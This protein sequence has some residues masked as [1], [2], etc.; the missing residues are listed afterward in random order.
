MLGTFHLYSNFDH[1]QTRFF[2][3]VFFVSRTPC[4]QCLL[5]IGQVFLHFQR[6]HFFLKDLKNVQPTGKRVSVVGG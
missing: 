2:L 4:S 5:I 6:W 3:F 1:M